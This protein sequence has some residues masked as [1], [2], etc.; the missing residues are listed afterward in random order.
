MSTPRINLENIIKQAVFE[1]KLVINRECVKATSRH[2]RVGI[3]INKLR[4]LIGYHRTL[5]QI[6]DKHTKQ[7]DHTDSDP[8]SQ[9]T[10]DTLLNKKTWRD[11]GVLDNYN[12]QIVN[13]LVNSI[14]IDDDE[15]D[16]DVL[17]AQFRAIDSQITDMSHFTRR[18]SALNEESS[19]IFS[20]LND[21]LEE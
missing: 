4:T 8:L 21:L 7:W 18:F 19:Q 20:K 11:I 9:L 15:Y 1:S 10:Y 17:T 12:N 13:D 16:Y 3:F 6:Y 2:E 14:P 5:Y